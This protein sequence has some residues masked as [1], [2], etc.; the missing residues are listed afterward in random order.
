MACRDTYRTN[1]YDFY[2]EETDNFAE[3]DEEQLL[4]GVDSRIETDDKL[5]NNISLF[6]WAKRNKIYPS[7]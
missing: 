7:F 1:V 3:W 4:F 5:Q 6:E 2:P